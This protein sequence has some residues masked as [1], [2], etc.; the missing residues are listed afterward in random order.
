MKISEIF[1]SIQGE[2]ALVGVPSVFVRTSGCNLRCKWCDTPY[3]SWQPEG[4]EMTVAEIVKTVKDYPSRHVVVTGGE[5]MIAPG[6]TELTEA[7]HESGLHITI[8]TAG[9]VATPVTCDLMS[10]SPKLSSST[11]FER[12][13]GRWAAQHERLRYQPD[14]LRHL[15]N[16][17]DY[18]LKFVLTSP[19]DLDEIERMCRDLQIPT[20]RVML[21][22]EG[23]KREAI[24]EKALWIVD[25]CKNKGYRYSPR[26]HIDLWGDRRGV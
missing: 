25:V 5:P 9:T 24:S 19:N 6:I 11:P 18:Q 10:I 8:E 23:T 14:V 22:P 2:G 4:R 3:T 17:Y 20:S 16:S 1:Y 26:L 13:N 12:E 21:M 15:T 7:L